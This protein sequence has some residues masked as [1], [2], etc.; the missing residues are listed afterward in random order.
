MRAMDETQEQVFQALMLHRPAFEPESV[1]WWAQA[2]STF[3]DSIKDYGEWIHCASALF[4]EMESIQVPQRFVRV[5]QEPEA[6]DPLYTTIP[7]ASIPPRPPTVESAYRTGY[8]KGVGY[9]AELV[10]NPQDQALLRRVY[11]E[12][13]KRRLGLT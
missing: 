3:L 11:K 2:A 12:L 10:R 13:R 7:M 8:L 5:A 6:E 1:G 9:A 4:P